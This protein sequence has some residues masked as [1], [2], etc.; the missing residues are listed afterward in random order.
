MSAIALIE[1]MVSQGMSVD[2]VCQE[3]GTLYYVAP[4]LTEGMN[5]FGGRHARLHGRAEISG[6]VLAGKKIVATFNATIE[7]ARR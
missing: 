7:L 4:G 3:C 2:M 6:K 1:Q 5:H